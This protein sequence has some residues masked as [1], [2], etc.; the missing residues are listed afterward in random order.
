MKVICDSSK[1]LQEIQE[2]STW[3][4]GYRGEKQFM[5]IGG[6]RKLLTYSLSAPISFGKSHEFPGLQLADVIASAV[7]YA[8]RNRDDEEANSWLKQIDAAHTVQDTILPDA[9]RANV[10]HLDGSLNSMLLI[11]LV[12]RAESGKPLLTGIEQSYVKARRELPGMI[13]EK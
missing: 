11:E 9:T 4:V 3:R 5:E 8:M 7:S 1:P 12:K 2:P 6:R 13:R 10:G